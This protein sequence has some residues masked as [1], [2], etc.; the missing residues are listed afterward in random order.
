MKLYNECIMKRVRG[1]GVWGSAI[2][3]LD[4]GE[5]AWMA[6]GWYGKHGSAFCAFGLHLGFYCSFW[7]VLKWSEWL[8][9]A[10]VFY[11]PFLLPDLAGDHL[12]A[13]ELGTTTPQH[14]AYSFAI[15]MCFPS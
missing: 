1:L 3:A 5:C 15:I 9:P 8:F 4:T 7:K 14:L 12:S 11:V 2:L 6:P 10:W 13:R